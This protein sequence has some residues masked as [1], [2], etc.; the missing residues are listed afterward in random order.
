MDP[1]N[2]GHWIEAQDR[3]YLAQGFFEQNVAA[4]PAIRSAAELARAADAIVEAMAE[5]YQR[6]GRA[7]PD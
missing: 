6:V 4:H 7:R 1:I 5:F 2:P 3:A